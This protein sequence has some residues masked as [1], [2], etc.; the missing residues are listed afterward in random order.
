MVNLQFQDRVTQMLRQIVD[1]Q[2]ELHEIVQESVSNRRRGKPADEFD[3]PS[4]VEA[5]RNGYAM[6]EQ[7]Q[8]HDG[9]DEQPKLQKEDE[10]TFF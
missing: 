8:L 9:Q 4:W 2:Q 3:V 1:T 10:I 5:M 6:V 7:H